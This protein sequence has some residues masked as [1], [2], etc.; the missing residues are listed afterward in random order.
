MAYWH[1][2]INRDKLIQLLNLIEW[3]LNKLMIT[4]YSVTC[5]ETNWYEFILRVSEID[6]LN[7]DYLWTKTKFSFSHGGLYR[8][9]GLYL[10][11]IMRK[12]VLAICEQQRRRPACAMH[13]LISTFIVHY[14]DSI[15]PLVSKSKM[16]RLASLCSWAAGLSLPWL[17]TPKTG[18]LLTWLIYNSTDLFLDIFSDGNEVDQVDKKLRRKKVVKSKRRHTTVSWGSCGLSGRSRMLFLH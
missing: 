12:S 10:S 4:L 14:L 17:K 8:L 16:S 13:S 3:N 2:W 15:I 9:V 5:L 11:H 1:N 7:K 6:P 18:F